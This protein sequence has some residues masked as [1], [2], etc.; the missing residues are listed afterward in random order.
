MLIPLTNARDNSVMLIRADLIIL[1]EKRNI[2]KS[3]LTT[4]IM[5]ETGPLTFDVLETQAQILA[6]VNT[7]E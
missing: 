2:L 5:T 7:E 6:L 1:V 3:V 4:N